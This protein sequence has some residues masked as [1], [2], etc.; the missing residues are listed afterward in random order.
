MTRP[1]RRFGQNRF[2]SCHC[3]EATLAPAHRHQRTA[4]CR[5][6][7]SHPDGALRAAHGA[8]HRTS[9]PTGSPRRSDGGRMRRWCLLETGS[10]C[11]APV[12]PCLG[13][14]SLGPCGP[15]GIVSHRSRSAMGLAASWSLDLPVSVPAFDR[16]ADRGGIRRMK[17]RF[18]ACAGCAP[19]RGHPV[20][21]GPGSLD[22]VAGG[23]TPHRRE[24]RRPGVIRLPGCGEEGGPGSVATEAA[25]DVRVVS[26]RMH[27]PAGTGP[28]RRW[29]RM[30]YLG[31]PCGSHSTFR[32]E[33][34]RDQFDPIRD[35]V[36]ARP[37]RERQA[38][39][40]GPFLRHSLF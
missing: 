3:C 34:E 32:G 38:A 37:P 23:V 33:P 20:S 12:A 28:S 19:F 15:W 35:A 14:L 4:D 1:P 6:P 29:S 16:E 30:P 25:I 13:R 7:Y 11:S 2:N 26:V 31:L 9:W 27:R 10:S 24:S 22:R 17:G 21:L 40:Q 5:P 39:R 36:P 8:V 18:P